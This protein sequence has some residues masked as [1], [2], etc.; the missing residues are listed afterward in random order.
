M[1]SIFES[2][3]L[4]GP[5]GTMFSFL[6]RITDSLVAWQIYEIYKLDEQA[7]VVCVLNWD[8]FPNT[9]IFPGL[10]LIGSLSVPSD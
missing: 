6:Y 4:V 1:K 9:S 3:L 2:N 10:G 7:W 5:G 8:A